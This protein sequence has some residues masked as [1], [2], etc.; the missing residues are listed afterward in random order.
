MGWRDASE[1]EIRRDA[2]TVRLKENSVIPSWERD[3]IKFE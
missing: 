1:R 2:L 3:N